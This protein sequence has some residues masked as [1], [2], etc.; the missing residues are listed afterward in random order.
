MRASACCWNSPTY[1]AR[2]AAGLSEDSCMA[3]ASAIRTPRREIFMLPATELIVEAVASWSESRA[4]PSK[5]AP[6]AEVAGNVG[7]AGGQ[8]MADG[9]LAAGVAE[10]VAA[11]FGNAAGA[12][13]ACAGNCAAPSNRPTRPASTTPCI[14]RE[15]R[16][17]RTRSGA[18]RELRAAPDSDVISTCTQSPCSWRCEFQP[19][20]IA[21][22]GRTQS[23]GVVAPSHHGPHP[24][25]S[26][27]PMPVPDLYG[28]ERDITVSIPEC[29][30]IAVSE[31]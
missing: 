9:A 15:P 6:S 26:D 24:I 12:T 14:D 30:D 22:N 1:P 19:P 5:V 11:G 7:G 16:R 18:G 8:V 2:T 25:E 27:G 23:V 4:M 29:A 3:T 31:A 13:A 28:Q 10:G 17:G 20:S 21:P